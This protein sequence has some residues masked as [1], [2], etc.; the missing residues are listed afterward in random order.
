MAAQVNTKQQYHFLP[1]NKGSLVHIDEPWLV[2]FEYSREWNGESELP[3]VVNPLHDVYRHP[4]TWGKPDVR[5][6]KLHDIYSLGVVL[7]EIG[8][9]QSVFQLDTKG[10]SRLESTDRFQLRHAFID[11]A[12]EDLPFRAGSA[13]AAVV[14]KCLSGEFVLEEDSSRASQP[15]N[16]YH[17]KDQVSTSRSNRRNYS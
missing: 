2:G 13:Y 15:P 8:L 5:F 9:W 16:S 7:L 17:Y 4:Q 11:A 1:N 14:E 6:N 12:R 3:T 10:F